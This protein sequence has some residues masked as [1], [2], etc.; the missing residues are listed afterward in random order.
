MKCQ[1]SPQAVMTITHKYSFLE[2]DFNL[3]LKLELYLRLLLEGI[4]N[5]NTP[6]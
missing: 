3:E 1:N 5:A 2:I 4:L 6:F